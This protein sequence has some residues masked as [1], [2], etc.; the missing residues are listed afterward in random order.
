MR[1]CHLKRLDW[2]PAF[3]GMTKRGDTSNSSLRRKPESSGIKED[4][5]LIEVEAVSAIPTPQDQPERCRWVRI[6]IGWSLRTVTMV[7]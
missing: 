3:A 4:E 7:P 1:V 5:V 6:H 2:I